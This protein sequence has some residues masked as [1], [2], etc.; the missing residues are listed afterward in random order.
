MGQCS[1]PTFSG[2]LGGQATV[3][4]VEGVWYELVRNVNRMCASLT[5]QVRTWSS[6]HRLYCWIVTLI[7]I[8][9]FSSPL[10]PSYHPYTFA[11]PRLTLPR[12]HK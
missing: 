9:F 7:L 6:A 3:P 2:K 11:S 12:A 4:D 1:C 10:P 8:T 5:D